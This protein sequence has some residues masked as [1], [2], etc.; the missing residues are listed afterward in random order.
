MAKFSKYVVHNHQALVAG[1]HYDLRIQIPGRRLLASW[2]LP[3]STI[4][5]N[6]TQRLLAIRGNDHG[7]HWLTLE[8]T[9]KQGENGV[10]VYGAGTIKIIETGQVEILRWSDRSMIT[11]RGESKLL[12]GT[13]HLVRF[14]NSKFKGKNTWFL[15]RGKDGEQ[16]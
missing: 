1:P 11:F 5:V 14:N 12:H 16:K 7:F 10:K 2:A 8:G 3:K 13:F 9:I 4:P 6:S 15:L